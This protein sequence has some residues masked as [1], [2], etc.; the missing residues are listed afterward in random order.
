MH[1]EIGDQVLAK[2]GML[3]LVGAVAH[4]AERAQKILVR[5]SAS[6][7][8]W[9]PEEALTAFDSEKHG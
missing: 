1:Y 8:D 6:Q 2:Y 3:P 7:Q 5:F 4:I 9:Y